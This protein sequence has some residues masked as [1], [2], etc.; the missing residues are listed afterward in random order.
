MAQKCLFANDDEFD[1][2]AHKVAELAKFSEQWRLNVAVKR[3]Y[4][5]E[6]AGSLRT[7][8]KVQRRTDKCC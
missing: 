2:Y 1:F 8:G 3:Y 7:D 5:Y 4:L 6:S